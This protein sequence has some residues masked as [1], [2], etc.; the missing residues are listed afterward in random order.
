MEHCGSAEKAPRHHASDLTVLIGPEP[1]DDLVGRRER[2]VEL[3]LPA[4][5]LDLI[6]QGARMVL[7]YSNLEVL[8]TATVESVTD[9]DDLVE[10]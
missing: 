5:G 3:P 4:Q 9:R 8:R 6:D 10:T 2:L 1:L 7:S